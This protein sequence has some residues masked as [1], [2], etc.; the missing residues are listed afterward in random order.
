VKI[1]EEAGSVK[2]AIFI[3]LS[4][5]SQW[6]A[7]RAR[8]RPERLIVVS[9]YCSMGESRMAA[10]PTD[11]PRHHYTLE[12]YFALEQAS[13]ARFEYWDGD[14]V[15]M[16]GGTLAHYRITRNLVARLEQ[17]LVEGPCEVFT[18]AFP[19][20]TPTLLPYRYPDLSVVCGAP[21]IENI[22]GVDALLNPVMIIEVL[23]PSGESRDRGDKFK[24]YQAIE[25]FREHLLVAQHVPYITHYTRESAGV[26][27]RNDVT[28]LEAAVRLDSAACELFLA[29]VYKGVTFAAPS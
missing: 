20:K 25:S 27:L 29:E 19:V 7:G 4:N 2:L 15:C 3:G 28:G 6:E 1:Q 9:Y 10:N 13:D 12:E 16:S 8:V 11:T 5:L 24:A 14:I 22:G 18:E 21:E 23:S 17:K 26:W